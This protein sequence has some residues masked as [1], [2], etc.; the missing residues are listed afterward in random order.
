MVLCIFLCSNPKIYQNIPVIIVCNK[1]DVF[2]SDG[3][4]VGG[5]PSDTNRSMAE[6][7]SDKVGTINV[8][9]LK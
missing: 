7:M 2:S 4:E 6:Q 1:T 8:R 9:I 5:C 3:R